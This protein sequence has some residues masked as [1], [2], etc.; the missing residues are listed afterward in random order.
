MAVEPLSHTDADALRALLNRDTAH[1][2]YFLG[3]L[4]EFGFDAP[5]GRGEFAYFGRTRRG[6]LTAAIFVGGNGGLVV[7]AAS[8]EPDFTELCESLAGRFQLQSAL[9]D[10]SLVQIACRAL[11]K[12]TPRVL[13]EQRLFKVSADD[14]GPFTNPTLRLAREE[15]VPRLLPLASGAAREIYGRDPQL[16]DPR[17]FEARVRQRVR[18]ERTYVLEEGGALVFKIDVGARSEYGAELEA[19]YTA[20][21]HRRK[22]HAILSLGQISRHLLSSL[23]RLTLR[24]AEDSPVGDMA[25]KVGYVAGKAQRLVVM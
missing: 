7:P 2:L 5:S 4:E 6:E 12:G 23:P 3:L 13:K 25:R 21:E 8:S 16:E 15:D 11:A 1:N 10:R 22:R 9:G 14:L 17:G 24:V 20:P 18:G 19:P